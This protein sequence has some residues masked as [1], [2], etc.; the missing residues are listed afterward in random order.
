MFYKICDV[1]NETENQ[2]EACGTFL[3]L[4]TVDHEVCLQSTASNVSMGLLMK[5]YIF[6]YL[7]GWCVKLQLWIKWIKLNGNN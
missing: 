5:R 6:G 2:Q 7:I 1:L 4:I 3:T